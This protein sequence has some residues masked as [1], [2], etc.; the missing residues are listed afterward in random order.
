[1]PPGRDK[2]MIKISTKHYERITRRKAQNLFNNGVSVCILANKLHPENIYF[3]PYEFNSN[4]ENHFDSVINAY[5]Y[6]NCNSETG[7]GVNY[8]VRKGEEVN[9]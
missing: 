4:T 5:I 6:Y 1:M 3:S 8:Y 9:V 7:H 2:D